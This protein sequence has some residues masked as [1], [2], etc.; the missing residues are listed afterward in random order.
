MACVTVK[1]ENIKFKH[2]LLMVKVNKNLFELDALLI[3]KLHNGRKFK[4][5]SYFWQL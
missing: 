5:G 2:K 3:F 1:I 4:P